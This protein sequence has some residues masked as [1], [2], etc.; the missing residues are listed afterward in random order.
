[1]LEVANFK[2]LRSAEKMA[3]RAPKLSEFQ[4]SP[5]KNDY[6]RNFEDE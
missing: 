3:Y 4:G 6:I 5:F 1:M 2:H